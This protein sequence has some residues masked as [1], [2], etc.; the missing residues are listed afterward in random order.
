MAR[1]QGSKRAVLAEAREAWICV[2]ARRMGRQPGHR[3]FRAPFTYRFW[4]LLKA[5]FWPIQWPSLPKRRY[6]LELDAV[7]FMSFNSSTTTTSAIATAVQ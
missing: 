2:E 6:K 3:L 5:R 7:V 1:K 4:A